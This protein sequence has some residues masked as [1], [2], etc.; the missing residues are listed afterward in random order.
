MKMCFVGE[1]DSVG[2]EQLEA[3]ALSQDRSEECHNFQ[4]QLGHAST[5]R[6]KHISPHRKRKRETVEASTGPKSPEP[7][8]VVQRELDGHT[9]R[10]GTSSI[11]DSLKENNDSAGG[12][13]RRHSRALVFLKTL[14]V[15]RSPYKNPHFFLAQE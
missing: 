14:T 10:T 11:G 4:S 5:Q 6:E 3:E 13:Q 8:A 15:G 7:S 9:T 12:G 2:L 1:H